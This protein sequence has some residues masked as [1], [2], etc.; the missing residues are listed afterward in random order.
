MKK[1]LEMIAGV[2][3]TN[4]YE[5]AVPIR[6]SAFVDPETLNFAFR[7]S[8]TPMAGFEPIA[9]HRIGLFQDAYR[10]DPP[11]KDAYRGAIR[12]RLKN[13][14]SRGGRKYDMATIN[15]RY[16]LPPYLRQ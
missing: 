6:E 8:F 5:P 4:R 7:P 11:D 16:P 14:P 3:D 15:E 13:T 9:F 1:H 2:S 10:P 12:E